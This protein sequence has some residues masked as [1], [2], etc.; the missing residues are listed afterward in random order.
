MDDK[1]LTLS[2]LAQRVFFQTQEIEDVIEM[3]E[4]CVDSIFSQSDS[5]EKM[6][7]KLSEID[8]NSAGGT[9][10]LQKSPEFFGVSGFTLKRENGLINGYC[11]SSGDPFKK[12][13]LNSRDGLAEYA[14]VI[15]EEAAK[16]IATREAVK[17]FEIRKNTP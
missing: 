11:Y 1:D 2:A 9:V 14:L 7:V 15:Y 6:G 8:N 4:K 10:L 3:L 16:G 13:N 5:Y 12:Y 17:R